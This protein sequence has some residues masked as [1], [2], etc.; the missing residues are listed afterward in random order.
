MSV[1][2]WKRTYED[3]I[4]YFMRAWFLRLR[5]R[6][7]KCRIV[8]RWKPRFVKT[9]QRRGA[10][11]LW[12][13]DMWGFAEGNLDFLKDVP[14]ITSV[15]VVGCIEDTGVLGLPTL[16]KISLQTDCNARIDFTKFPQLEELTVSKRPGVET[17]FRSKTIT[18]LSVS[19]APVRRTSELSDMTSLKKLILEP[20]RRLEEVDWLPEGIEELSIYSAPKLTFNK[21][22]DAAK[23]LR[24]LD[25][26]SCKNIRDL[27]FLSQL[28]ELEYLGIAE[29][30]EYE[31]LAPLA[32]CKKLKMLIAHG[33]TR[34]MDN[35]LSVLN[36][37]PEL[38]SEDVRLI[39]R[40]SYFG[41]EFADD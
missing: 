12:L 35:D 18:R 15:D 17:A 21:L 19:S 14:F 20:C 7:N 6:G 9:L 22:P 23:S 3:D 34:I 31:S 28:P 29:G 13:N 1:G 33:N 11:E 2:I 8:G 36:E 24:K 10:T 27:S 37:L 41:Y 38:A 40:R 16:R 30:G 4:D 32:N 39:E 26:E 5:F 25:I